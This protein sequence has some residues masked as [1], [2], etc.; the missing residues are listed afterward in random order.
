M[1]ACLRA[2]EWV[3]VPARE[4]VRI[5]AWVCVVGGWVWGISN[6]FALPFPLNVLL[7]PFEIAE[8]ILEVT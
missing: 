4:I 2:C 1:C 5:P 6:G 7:L 3:C 8:G